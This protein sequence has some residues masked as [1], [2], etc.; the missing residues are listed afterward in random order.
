MRKILLLFL[1]FLYTGASAELP[2]QLHY[3]MD[4]FIGASVFTDA[5]ADCK[6]CGMQGIE[7][8][9]EECCRIEVMPLSQETEVSPKGEAL[10]GV[11]IHSCGLK[12]QNLTFLN[13]VQI[14][15]SADTSFERLPISS[16]EKTPLY[17]RIRVLRI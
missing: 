15:N 4:E 3:C 6:N 8:E 12:P 14:P 13:P 5:D 17:L 2:M 1:V 16:S 10:L 7:Q 11:K 9:E